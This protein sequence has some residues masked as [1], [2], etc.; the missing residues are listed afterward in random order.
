V[1][2]RGETED[3]RRAKVRERL[4]TTRGPA[5][6]RS[7]NFRSPAGVWRRENER[8]HG[9]DDA[10]YLV[11]WLAAKG[12]LTLLVFGGQVSVWTAFV[13][14]TAISV[15]VLAYGWRLARR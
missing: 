12:V 11:P 14:D 10:D 1:S 3:E 9:D 4:H 7:R 6:V 8:S 5:G 13:L 15:L 2:A